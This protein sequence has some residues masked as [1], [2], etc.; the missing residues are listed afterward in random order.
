[1]LA[2]ALAAGRQGQPVADLLGAPQTALRGVTVDAAVT[3]DPA[4]AR[5]GR[6][7]RRQ[8]IDRDPVDAT[9][10]VRQGRFLL[11]TESVDGRTVDQEALLACARRAG[12][13]SWTPRP[14]SEVDIPYTTQSPR[15]ETADVEAATAA[16]ERMAAD[17]V[18]TRGD[19]TWTITG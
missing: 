7:C 12:S 5:G 14:R 3:Y 2:A 6:R 18:L 15:H 10:A 9:L 13:R 17:L 8:A 19:K 16:A 4:A 11:T 1:M